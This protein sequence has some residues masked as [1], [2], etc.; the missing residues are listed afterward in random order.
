MADVKVTQVASSTPYDNED[1]GVPQE[2][3]Q[4]VIDAILDGSIGLSATFEAFE[5]VGIQSTTSNGW[6]TKSGYP[7]TT[8]TKTAGDYVIDYSA[9]I[10]QSDKEKVV[11]YQVQW[12]PGTTGTW[13]ELV[14]V[15]DGLSIDD[16]YQLR[17]GFD[18]ITLPSDGVFQVRVRWGQTDEGGTGRIQRAAIKISKVSN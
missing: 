18:I 7:Y 13:L 16:G 3:V 5:S 9:Q 12:R 15:R 14:D 8:T 2:D 11:G 17:T 1:S 6:I 10:G 4:E